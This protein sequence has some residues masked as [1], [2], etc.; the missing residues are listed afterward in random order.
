M[1]TVGN[2]SK[3]FGGR[4]LFA[5]VSLRFDP[6]SRTAIVGPNGAGKTTLMKILAGA[7]KPDSGEVA[8]Q[9]GIEIGVL[10]QDVAEWAAGAAAEAGASPTPVDL[11][12]AGAPVKALE[13]RLEQLGHALAEDPTSDQLLAE[14]C[15]TQD[16]FELL[17]GYDLDARARRILGGLGFD[18]ATLDQPLRSLSG[19]WMM[20]VALGRLLL[21]RPEVLLLDE[22]TNHLD[23]DS[24]GW[25]QQFL[26]AYE[27]AVVLVSHDRDFINAMAN[28][29]V[30]VDDGRVTSYPGDYEAFITARAE[31]LELLL[32]QAKNQAKK[33]AEIERFVDRFRYKASKARQVQSRVKMLDK[34]DR[35][36][37]DDRKRRT[38]KLSFGEAP[39]S[40]RTVVELQGVSKAYGDNVV[41]RDLDLALE[42]GQKVALVGPNGAGKSTLLKM[43][44][45]ELAPQS[46]SRELGHNVH[47][48]YYAQHQVDAL[49]MDKTALQEVAASVDTSKV[50]PRDV[51]G[52]FLFSGEDVDKRIEVLSGGERARVALAKL[53]ATPANLLCMDEPTNHLDIA[54]RD[55]I[56]DALIDYPGTV[57]L[58]SHDRH[59]IRSVA[60]VIISVGEGRAHVHLGDYTSYAE[61]VGLDYLGRTVTPTA[62]AA[63]PKGSP[64]AGAAAKAAQKANG[65]ADGAAERRDKREDAERRN[66]LHTRTKDL[67]SKLKKAETA[68]MTAE[69]DVAAVQRAMAEPGAYEDPDAARELTAR[70]TEAKDRAHRLTEEWEGLVEALDA[71]EA[72]VS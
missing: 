71:A 67:R 27:G 29:I 24:V 15:G 2:V 66:R 1:I 14:L 25:L 31:R 22:P 17:G 39:R 33:V 18:E 42:R 26:A 6:G 69:E 21:R 64:N 5:D 55:V 68:L 58:I 30:E 34:M 48:S 51:L 9:K 46:G 40:G 54:S 37:V 56:E 38:M 16:R 47:V 8:V 13:E 65:R 59:L 12:V 20:R 62:P 11:V 60:D 23:L 45:G 43:L 32:A 41:Y 70:H 10:D 36:E 19:G 3:G 63:A 52:S 61:K 72:S 50:N 44:V 7:D 53:I 49:H 57:V 28:Q 4:T 35:V